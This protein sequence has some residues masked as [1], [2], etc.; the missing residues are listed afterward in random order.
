LH[1]FLR[2]PL[3]PPMPASSANDDQV[4]PIRTVSSLTGVSAITLRAWERRYGLV[5]PDRTPGGQRA[6]TQANIDAIHQILAQLHKGVSI[7]QVRQQPPPT[8]AR[9]SRARRPADLWQN[10][11]V[12]MTA[13]IAQFDEDR[14]EDTYNDVLSLYPSELVTANVLQPLLVELGERWRNTSGS[15]AEE[16]FFGV[17][18]RNKLGARFH[19]RARRDSGARLLA[20]CLPGEFHE[21]GL[22]LFALAAHED[23]FRPVLLG[24]D[25]PLAELAPAAH[26]SRAAAIVLSGA[27]EP[28]PSLLAEELPALVAKAGVPVFIGGPRAVRDRDAIAA[29]GAVPLGEDVSHALK[30]LAD[31]LRR[32]R[33]R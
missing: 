24:A 32:P 25:M 26:R 3:Q 19:H 1:N 14:L 23:G 21:V 16:H 20:A 29:A 6:Y 18:L 22:L 2:F 8:P 31:A 5:K 13:A 33:A 7:G 10:Y 11:R 4:F 27:I 9:T 15:I 28:R 12:R 17:Y 30:R